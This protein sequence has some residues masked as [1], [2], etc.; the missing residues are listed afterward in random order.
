MNIYKCNSKI[1]IYSS[2]NQAKLGDKH[3]FAFWYFMLERIT[4]PF[5][6][7]Q[8]TLQSIFL[9]LTFLTI[10]GNPD[11]LWAMVLEVGVAEPQE[12]NTLL[13]LVVASL[14]SGTTGSFASTCTASSCTS[15]S[16]SAIFYPGH[17]FSILLQVQTIF[18]E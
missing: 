12:Q 2:V 7:F 13:P 17:G 18:Q 8:G 11:T 14:C 16:P 6:Y 1:K 4:H 5:L 15:H 9:Y 3:H 10:V